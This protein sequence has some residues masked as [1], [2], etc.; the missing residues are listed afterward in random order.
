MDGMNYFCDYTATHSVETSTCTMTD[1]FRFTPEEQAQ[2]FSSLH[3][4]FSDTISTAHDELLAWEMSYDFY[5]DTPLDSAAYRQKINE[6][7]QKLKD[8]DPQ[9]IVDK[10]YHQNAIDYSNAYR[11][12]CTLH[13]YPDRQRTATMLLDKI[14]YLLKRMNNMTRHTAFAGASVSFVPSSEDED[15][16]MLR[17]IILRLS[18]KGKSK[19]ESYCLIYALRDYCDH[20][21]KSW[22][23][24]NRKFADKICTLIPWSISSDSLTTA[25]SRAAENIKQQE[26]KSYHGIANLQPHHVRD[27][28][29]S[30][31]EC[32][33]WKERF[34]LVKSVYN[35]MA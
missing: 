34:A 30:K 16:A 6:Q 11:Y 15:T 3:D 2:Y 8:Q 20:V 33:L 7:I 5:H 22:A 9:L 1:V 13:P 12:I 19:K 24:S 32:K 17:Q 18:L 23:V 21:G 25:L 14:A 28:E 31:K 29:D 35:A 26:S 10:I 4:R 27:S